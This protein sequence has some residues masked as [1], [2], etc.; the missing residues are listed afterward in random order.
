M[1]SVMDV[2]R[3]YFAL[4]LIFLLM[5]LKAGANGGPNVSADLDDALVVDTKPFDTDGAAPPVLVSST[6]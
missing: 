1:S 3:F 4:L 6:E 2:S 5:N